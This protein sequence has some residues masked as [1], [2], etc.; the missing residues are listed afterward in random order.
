[1]SKFNKTNKTKEERRKAFRELYEERFTE[2]DLLCEAARQ[3]FGDELARMEE[4][5]NRHH[6]R[7]L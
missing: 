7:N 2:V 5:A 1:M 6:E 3:I 4:A